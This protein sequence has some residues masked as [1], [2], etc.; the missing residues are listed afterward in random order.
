MFERYHPTFLSAMEYQRGNREIKPPT[1]NRRV[2][3]GR[4]GEIKQVKENPKCEALSTLM[5]K[6][7]ECIQS[8]LQT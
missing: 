6:I 1:L 3:L 4:Q 5:V 7:Q 2:K 8:V